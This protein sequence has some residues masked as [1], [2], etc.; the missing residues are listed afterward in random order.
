MERITLF[1]IEV[2]SEKKKDFLKRKRTPILLEDS[3][4]LKLF[5]F[6]IIVEEKEQHLA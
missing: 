6:I 4:E 1:R 3:R 2:F 5:L